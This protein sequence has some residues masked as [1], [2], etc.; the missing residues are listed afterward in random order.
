VKAN[1]P[2]IAG[3]PAVYWEDELMAY[4]GG[5]HEAD[6][7]LAQGGTLT[8]SD[9]IYRCPSDRSEVKAHTDPTTGTPNGIAN[10]TSYLLNAVLSHNTRRYG[11]WTLERWKDDVGLSQVIAFAERN[12]AAFGEG[13]ISPH[14]PGGPPIEG[15][16]PAADPDPRTDDFRVW[17]GTSTIRT[18][19]AARQH[20]HAANYLYLDGH[21]AVLRWEDSVPDLFPDKQVL[22]DDSRFP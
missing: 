20:T 2:Q 18:Q 1:D 3:T 6:R 13:A 10:R 7:T 12:P 22:T 14:P 4:V 21:V 17:L 19:I 9:V 16:A 5:Q 15:D 11:T 8:A